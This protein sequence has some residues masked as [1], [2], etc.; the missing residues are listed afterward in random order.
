MN[1]LNLAKSSEQENHDLVPRPGTLEPD[2]PR[3]LVDSF[4]DLGAEEASHHAESA[5][6]LIEYGADQHILNPAVLYGAS[7]DPGYISVTDYNYRMRWTYSRL[8]R[9]VVYRDDEEEI[10]TYQYGDGAGKPWFHRPQ[11]RR[12]RDL[13][14][15]SPLS[16]EICDIDS[17][18]PSG[19]RKKQVTTRWVQSANPVVLEDWEEEQRGGEGEYDTAEVDEQGD[20]IMIDA[21]QTDDA[22]MLENEVNTSDMQEEQMESE[23]TGLEE[24][25]ELPQP[26][27]HPAELTGNNDQLRRDLASAASSSDFWAPKLTNWADES[28][29]ASDFSFL[30]AALRSEAKILPH[31]ESLVAEADTENGEDESQDVAGLPDVDDALVCDSDDSNPSNPL[32][33]GRKIAPLGCS[34][35]QVSLLSVAIQTE[36]EHA[37]ASRTTDAG[38]D[39]DDDDDF[40][41]TGDELLP[42]DDEMRAIYEAY[43]DRDQHKAW[44]DKLAC[45]YSQVTYQAILDKLQRDG[46]LESL[47]DHESKKQAMGSTIDDSADDDDDAD[48][49]LTGDDLLP[50]PEE[51]LALCEAYKAMDPAHRERWLEVLSVNYAHVTCQAIID[52]FGRDGFFKDVADTEERAD[53]TASPDSEANNSAKTAVPVAE[54]LSSFVSDNQKDL[55]VVAK[56]LPAVAEPASEGLQPLEDSSGSRA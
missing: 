2:L 12:R 29:E 13:P 9:S 1:L 48:L 24:N 11:Q 15:K 23:D 17:Y 50:P 36:A 22:K 27:T 38:S 43:E 8:G 18:I 54:P 30:G 19:R 20:T 10:T 42:P 21:Q 6:T 25:E 47:A 46:L 39:V 34:S 56:E 45:D 44:Y 4:E 31:I 49:D 37:V 7:R 40:E 26:S 35:R 28:D 55:D 33:I 14:G 53:D 5:M 52:K 16:K 3:P 51:M 32:L 41:L